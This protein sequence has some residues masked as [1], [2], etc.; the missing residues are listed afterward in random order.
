MH[1]DLHE[2]MTQDEPLAVDAPTGINRFVSSAG[3]VPIVLDGV[4]IGAIGIFAGH[5]S[6]DAVVAEAGATSLI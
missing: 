1:D 3:D 4:M 5:W 6:Q 2:L